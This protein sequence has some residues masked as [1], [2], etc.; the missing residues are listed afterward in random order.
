MTKENADKSFETALRDVAT[1]TSAG[2]T[3]AKV[4]EGVSTQ[5]SVNH[6]DHRGRVFEIYTGGSSHW[7]KPLVY[8]YAFTVRPGQAKGWGL[9]EHKD[10]RYTLISGEVLTVLYDARNDSPTKGLVQ[11]VILTAEG[12]R[13]LRIPTGVWH[14]NICIGQSEAFLINHPTEIYDHN[15]PD[16]LLLPWDSQDIPVDIS[17]FFQHS[18]SHS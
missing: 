5:T 18:S 10:D 17:S 14:I 11:K 8:C 13:Q 4:I 9:H 15:A 1:V 6:V 3:L 7:Q 12:T 16:R 2:E